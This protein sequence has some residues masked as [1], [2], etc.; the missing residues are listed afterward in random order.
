LNLIVDRTVY[1]G[2]IS[3]DQHTP[4]CPTKWSNNIL[5]H[6]LWPHFLWYLICEKKETWNIKYHSG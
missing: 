6:N 5:I 1:R 3:L 2:S 4:T